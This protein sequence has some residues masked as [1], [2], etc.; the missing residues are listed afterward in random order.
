MKAMVNRRLSG[1]YYHV[2][3][4]IGEFTTDDVQKMAAFG[5]PA[6]QIQFGGAPGTARSSTQVALNQL[7][8]QWDA[9]FPTEEEAKKYEEAVLSQIRDAVK[10]LRESQDKFSSSEEVPL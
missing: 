2:N 7:S 8:P 9:A 1:G 10:R 6:I 5:A 4:L 3:F